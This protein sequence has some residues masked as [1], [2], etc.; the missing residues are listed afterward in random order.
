MA[1][2]PCLKVR[3]IRP[4]GNIAF[5]EELT[6]EAR[7]KLRFDRLVAACIKDGWIG[8]RVQC[9]DLDGNVVHER[10]ISA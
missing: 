2:G 5:T 3:L 4:D 6:S 8:S 1:R 10:K 7:A 9:L